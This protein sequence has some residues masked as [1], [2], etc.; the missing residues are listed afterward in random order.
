MLWM[1]HACTPTHTLTNIFLGYLLWYGNISWSWVKTQSSRLLMQ[2]LMNMLQTNV[3]IHTHFLEVKGVIWI[4]VMITCKSSKTMFSSQPPRHVIYNDQWV[5]QM[6]MLDCDF[7]K[8]NKFHVSYRN[9]EWY[10]V[11]NKNKF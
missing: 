8:L 9:I 11:A 5:T 2:N 1:F 3:Y 4:N 7:M 6:T 10:W